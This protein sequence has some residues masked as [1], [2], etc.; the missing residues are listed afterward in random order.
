MEK[1]RRALLEILDFVENISSYSEP[2]KIVESIARKGLELE[3]GERIWGY[4]EVHIPEYALIKSYN[5]FYAIALYE[6]ET[7]NEVK[8]QLKEISKEYA[9]L[10]FAKHILLKAWD[11][12]KDISVKMLLETF[13]KPESAILVK[14]KL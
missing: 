7:G 2:C 4:F 14:G 8:G 6:G 3:D 10:I 5:S 13:N 11:M 12:D 9:L 1:E